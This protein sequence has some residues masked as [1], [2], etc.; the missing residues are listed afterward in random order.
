MR[1]C[2]AIRDRSDEKERHNFGYPIV[3]FIKRRTKVFEGH[4]N[5]EFTY[6][7]QLE[8]AHSQNG[9]TTIPTHSFVV[10]VAEK[11]SQYEPN[12]SA[13]LERAHIVRGTLESRDRSVRSQRKAMKERR[14]ANSVCCYNSE[15]PIFLNVT[16]EMHENP[17]LAPQI[18]YG[19]NR[20][21]CPNRD[22]LLPVKPIY[23]EIRKS[24]VEL[25]DSC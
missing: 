10:M 23:A 15:V 16:L 19:P 18:A 2:S 20:I 5:G 25:F 4:K 9:M 17:N 11:R 6:N 8:K 22:F 1:R 7:T 24:I 14:F 3:G 13:D 21:C 12:T